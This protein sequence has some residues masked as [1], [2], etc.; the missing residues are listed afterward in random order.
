[1]TSHDVLGTWVEP[2]DPDPSKLD[3]VTSPAR[4]ANVCRFGGHTR[5]FYSVA[6]HSLTASELCADRGGDVE[7][8]LA[9]PMHEAT[10]AYLGGMP[11]PSSTAARSARPSR[12]RGPA[13]AVLA[14]GASRIKSDVPAIKRVDRALLATE[15]RGVQLDLLGLARARGRRAA[16]RSS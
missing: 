10:E 7:A 16:R 12:S 5:A 4:S 8:V 1:M 2:I 3:A 11:H 9:A 15:R 14:A 13:E 6:Q